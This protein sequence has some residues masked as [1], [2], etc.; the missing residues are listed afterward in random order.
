MARVVTA[1]ATSVTEQL[2][3]EREP[4]DLV[5]E[6]KKKERIAIPQGGNR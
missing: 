4:S 6:R 2:M 1:H 5:A 3:V